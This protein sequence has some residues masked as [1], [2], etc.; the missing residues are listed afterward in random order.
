M[1]YTLQSSTGSDT[2]YLRFSD[3]LHVHKCYNVNFIIYRDTR[4]INSCSITQTVTI[5][6]MF[7]Y[8]VYIEIR[9]LSPYA[10]CRYDLVR[11]KAKSGQC[12]MFNVQV[13]GRIPTDVS[14][15]I[16]ADVNHLL[17]SVSQMK[18]II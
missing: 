5:F 10:A 8:R 2:M 6:Q 1:H 7:F 18:V 13:E 15:R 17:F 12:L 4:F 3:H 11:L 14:E 9:T 16:A